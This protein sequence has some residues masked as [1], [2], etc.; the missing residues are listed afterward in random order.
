MKSN[1]N[2][3]KLQ[4]ANLFLWLMISLSWGVNGYSQVGVGTNTPNSKAALDISSANKGL[5]IP[6]VT[7]ANRPVTPPAGMMI[8]Q[9]DNIP[10]FYFY[11]GVKWQRI[12]AVD[13][14]DP[15]TNN[16]DPGATTDPGTT[17]GQT[18]TVVGADG[19]TYKTI[20]L[21]DQSV[22]LQQNLGS[23]R[24]ATSI[25]DAQSFGDLYQWGRWTDGHEK[26]IPLFSRTITSSD[27]NPNNPAGLIKAWGTNVNPYYYGE[28]YQWWVSGSFSDKWTA[29]KP[30]DVTNQLACDPCR[31]LLGGTWRLPTESEWLS[32]LNNVSKTLV[33]I[34]N[35]ETGYESWLRIPLGGYRDNL[36]TTIYSAS[37]ITYLWTSSAGNGSSGKC[38]ELKLNDNSVWTTEYRSLFDQRGYGFSL[39]CKKD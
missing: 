17:P 28:D 7:K 34:V 18:G 25:T 38:I 26:R 15:P 4:A 27:P 14:T 24:V 23:I 16:P 37:E 10:G 29:A 39:R 32:V 21:G 6:R 3:I 8:Y 11:T 20:R 1:K 12:Y 5:L 9:I 30:L 36:T 2:L 13:E 19:K 31:V 22:W 35:A 33:A